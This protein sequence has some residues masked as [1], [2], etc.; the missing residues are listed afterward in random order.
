MKLSNPPTPGQASIWLGLAKVSPSCKAFWFFESVCVCL[1]E[2]LHRY[3]APYS[4]DVQDSPHH[5]TKDCMSDISQ[6]SECKQKYM[7]MSGS[8]KCYKEKEFR[9]GDREWW[10]LFQMRCWGR[11]LSEEAIPV[12]G[13]EVWENKSH[14]GLWEVYF[15]WQEQRP[16][17]RKELQ[18]LGRVWRKRSWM[19]EPIPISYAPPFHTFG[20]QDICGSP[21]TS[22]RCPIRACEVL[23]W[24]I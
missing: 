24:Q 13:P 3:S 14:K 10:G 23:L 11:S 17:G 20:R 6:F 8:E 7:W 21:I 2:L 19:N 9:L 16:W 15:K 12:Q 5:H 22:G 1:E 4:T 18:G